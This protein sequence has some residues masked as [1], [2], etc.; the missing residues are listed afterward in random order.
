M[1]LDLVDIAEMT[2]T[3]VALHDWLSFANAVHLGGLTAEWA[4]DHFANPQCDLLHDESFVS[5]LA[6][7]RNGSCSET[8]SGKGSHSLTYLE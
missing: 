7:I 8:G 1:P 2:T 3:A 6:V 4:P 5:T